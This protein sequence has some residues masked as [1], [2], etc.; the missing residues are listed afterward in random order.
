LGVVR[1]M[2]IFGY[3]IRRL[4]GCRKEFPDANEKTNFITRLETARR[5][6]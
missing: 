4:T 3:H 1:E 2:K 6:N 5:I